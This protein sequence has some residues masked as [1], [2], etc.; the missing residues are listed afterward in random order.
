MGLNRDSL[1]VVLGAEQYRLGN[2][3]RTDLELFEGGLM[4]VVFD[5]GR[6]IIADRKAK[7]VIAVDAKGVP[8]LFARRG[9]GPGEVTYPSMVFDDIDGHVGLLD[10][11]LQ[12]LTRYN[13][14]GNKAAR[15][16]DY[17]THVGPGY[18]CAIGGRY[19][20]IYYTPTNQG[21]FSVY[22][23]DG[24]LESRFGPPFISGSPLRVSTHTKGRV[25]C[26]GSSPRVIS[27]TQ[28]GELLAYDLDGTF[29]WRKSIPDVEPGEEFGSA[30]EIGFRIIPRGKARSR[31]VLSL[32]ALS[33]SVGAVQLQE[34]TVP[35]VGSDDQFVRGGVLTKLFDL[36]TGLLLG[37][38][39][40][41]PEIL[42]ASGTKLLLLQWSD[43]AQWVRT[44]SFRIAAAGK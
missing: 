6:A 21:V 39:D 22:T 32:T 27:A 42:Y 40:D 25:I 15:V 11:A 7:Q 4:G 3:P 41:I 13:L 17:R 14:T 10:N 19:V 36:Q 44:T 24:K 5:D 38:Q 43:D 23:L 34:Y 30:E 37:E 18:S 8:A 12:R 1:R 31:W 20:G 28:G 29:L 9:S 33:A 35:P 2:P 16:D 26:V